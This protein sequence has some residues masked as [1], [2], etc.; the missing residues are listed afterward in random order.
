MSSSE[1]ITRSILLFY[2]F[3][4]DNNSCNCFCASC[5]V[6]LGNAFPVSTATVSTTVFVHERESA[7]EVVSAEFLFP[8]K[9]I[10]EVNHVANKNTA[11]IIIINNF[12]IFLCVVIQGVE[13]NK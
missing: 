13:K 12:K 1:H 7:H 6:M 11:K 4:P 5:L 8:A 2:F 9:Y 10:T 3:T